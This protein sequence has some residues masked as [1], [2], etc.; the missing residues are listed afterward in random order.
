MQQYI[1]VLWI[2]FPGAA[3]YV[4]LDSPFTKKNQKDEPGLWKKQTCDG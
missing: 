1:Q 2:F 3:K 4:L